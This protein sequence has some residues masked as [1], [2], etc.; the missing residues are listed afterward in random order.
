MKHFP[1]YL[2]TLNRVLQLWLAVRAINLLIFYAAEHSSLHTEA[3]LLVE[4]LCDTAHNRRITGA[5]VDCAQ[6][7]TLV[8]T[9]S[10]VV[11]Y[12]IEKTVRTIM[13]DCWLNATHGLSSLVQL[14]GL[15]ATLI[16]TSAICMQNMY[17]G[18]QR[19]R[20]AKTAYGESFL[21]TVGISRRITP[22]AL[23]STARQF[24]FGGELDQPPVREKFE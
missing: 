18:A 21:E 12:A 9:K 10:F 20:Y 24:D 14:L 23:R 7:R 17:L 1:V 6:A 5:L 4:H 3:R 2:L 11:T 16:F 19:I 8:N 22:A 15:M 13:L